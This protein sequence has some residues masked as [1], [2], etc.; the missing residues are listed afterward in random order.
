MAA[1]CPSSGHSLAKALDA[2]MARHRVVL[3]A[4]GLSSV[5]DCGRNSKRRGFDV[6]SARS[7]LASSSQHVTVRRAWS[8]RASLLVCAHSPLLG[9]RGSAAP[10]LALHDAELACFGFSSASAGGRRDL[11][12]LRVLRDD[13]PAPLLVI[14]HFILGIGVGSAGM[15]VHCRGA[16]ANAPR[17]HALNRAAA[18]RRS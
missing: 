18:W 4:G 8:V 12:P 16:A 11:V 2:L 10:R 6:L 3:C 15:R 5:C 17:P 13:T 1:S 9:L 14:A 7:F